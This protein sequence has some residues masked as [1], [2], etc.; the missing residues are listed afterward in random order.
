M[1][2]NDTS[3]ELYDPVSGTWS[4][5]GNMLKPHGGFPATLLSDGTVLVGDVDDPAA[6]DADLGRRGVR[7]GKRD[8]DRDGEDGRW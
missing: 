1:T 6:E 3:A 8:L 5:T 4:A 7:P 2:A